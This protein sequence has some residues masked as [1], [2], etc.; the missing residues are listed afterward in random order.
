[1]YLK[2]YYNV[3]QIIMK[4][5]YSRGPM[6]MLYM[7]V[8]ILNLSYVIQTLQTTLEPTLKGIFQNFING[9]HENTIITV[10]P[11]RQFSYPKWDYLIDD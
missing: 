8:Y 5:F 1:M 2:E 3:Q 11:K 7:V 9:S 10:D 4:T 6:A